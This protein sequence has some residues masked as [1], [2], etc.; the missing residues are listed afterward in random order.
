MKKKTKRIIIAV[1][2]VA[3]VAVA[4]I[5]F[6]TVSVNAGNSA[7][8]YSTD[9]ATTGD[10]SKAVSGSGNLDSA[11]TLNVTADSH[12]DISE[13][14][15]YTGDTL[16]EDQP[17]A[18]LN[19]EAMRDYSG[20]LKTQIDSVR[21]QID[22]TN[23][24][25]TRLSIKS[26][27]DGWV[28]NVLLDEDDSIEDAMNE[29]GYVALVATQERE[30]ISAEGSS[31][32]E[33]TA[34]RVKCESKWH[35]GAVTN[36]NGALYV[37]I[38]TIARTVGADAQVY[39][40]DGNLLFTGKIELAAYQ[41]IES[42]YGVITDAGFSE[43]E[44][45]EAGE[46]IYSAEQYSQDVMELY[47]SLSELKEEYDT[48]QALIEAGQLTSPVAGVVDTLS[49]AAG[50]TVDKGAS[51]M[52]VDSTDDWV[53]TVSVDELDIN[54]IKTGQYVS[55]TLDSMPNDTF[56]GKVTR[57]SELGSA[58][59]G[60]TTYD[61]DVTVDSNENFKL[62]MTVSCE[63]TSEE[64]KNA[65]LVPVDD[66]L[67]ANNR[68]YVMAAVERTDAEKNAIKQLISDNDYKGLADFMG[69]DAAALNITM[70]PDPEQLL[71]SEVRAVETGIENAYYVEI[72]S[73][74]SEGEKIIKQTSDS[75]D[76]ESGFFMNGMGAM[77]GGQ[78]GGPPSGGGGAMG[79]GQRPDGGFGRN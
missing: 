77:G 52:T 53:A 45:I 67:T 32:A 65:V 17:V 54:S 25:T 18:S 23:N 33:G 20:D 72:K 27:V 68:S 73:G 49:L 47:A 8:T 35:N 56:S 36:E 34:V 44:E 75:S 55:V 76:S 59:N 2:A 1:A 12:L 11:K 38:D 30:L 62:G 28:K 66:V 22:T 69:E 10:I 41:K 57:V 14:L 13:V 78:M 26:P 58:S 74:L 48:L 31:L 79:G 16:K 43:D 6:S 64:A 9:I 61:V 50:Q 71:Y 39:D 63:I 21:T 40:A 37:S 24:T 70:L 60:I 29:Y 7:N 4:V 3:L 19:I 15:V 46:T 5:I 51:L 42:S